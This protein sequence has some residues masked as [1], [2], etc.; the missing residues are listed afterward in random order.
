MEMASGGEMYDRVVAKG[1]YSEAEAR[2]ALRML[3][4][5]LAYLHGIRVTHRDLKPENLL[6]SDS[7]PDARLLITDFGLAHQVRSPQEKM[8][9]TCGTP[10][11]IAPE[12]IH[13]SVVLLLLYRSQ[14]CTGLLSVL[15][16]CWLGKM[17][18]IPTWK[19]ITKILGLHKELIICWKRSET[20]RG[21]N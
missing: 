16:H 2:Q 3:L 1:R 19:S 9:E 17:M 18:N 4:S 12:V 8:T 11:Y 7:R 5:G 13:L 6:Y 10:E 20:S 21:L 15:L 14:Q